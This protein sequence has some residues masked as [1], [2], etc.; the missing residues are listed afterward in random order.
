MGQV[1]PLLEILVGEDG[2]SVE[3]GGC[4]DVACGFGYWVCGENDGS[5]EASGCADVGCGVE[6]GVGGEHVC[7]GEDDGGSEDF[8]NG[9]NSGVG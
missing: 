4:A 6:Y 5:C 7:C 8:V 2:D 1:S 9:E 3:E